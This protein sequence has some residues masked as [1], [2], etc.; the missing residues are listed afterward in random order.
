MEL[1]QRYIVE[2]VLDWTMEDGMT[3]REIL[4]DAAKADINARY[5]DK[6]FYAKSVELHHLEMGRKPEFVIVLTD[7]IP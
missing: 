1:T 4:M 3:F 7:S 6:N 2:D 5:L